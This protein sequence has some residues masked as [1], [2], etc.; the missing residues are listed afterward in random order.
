MRGGHHYE[1][2]KSP[3]ILL[4]I[5]NIMA[6][7]LA[8]RRK[9]ANSL[10]TPDRTNERANIQQFS[11]EAPL[12]AP[13]PLGTFGVSILSTSVPRFLLLPHCFQPQIPPCCK[14]LNGEVLV[15][16]SAVVGCL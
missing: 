15:W 1:H 11:G 8:A 14:E 9:T 16:L 13:Y 6:S 4:N 7:A 3:F 10:A 2:E 12:P 5:L